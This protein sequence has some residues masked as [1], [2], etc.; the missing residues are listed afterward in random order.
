M[1]HNSWTSRASKRQTDGADCNYIF[2]KLLFLKILLIRVSKLGG[3]HLVDLI[4]TEHKGHM[5]NENTGHK[6]S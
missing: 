2:E 5:T 1:T 3:F 6:K 4:I